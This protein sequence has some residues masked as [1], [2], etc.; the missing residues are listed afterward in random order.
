LFLDFEQIKENELFYVA[1]DAV[2][3]HIGMEKV[4]DNIFEVS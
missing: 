4:H 3:A 2:L 1:V